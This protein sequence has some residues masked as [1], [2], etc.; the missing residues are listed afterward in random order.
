[1]QEN[2]S[3]Y[4]SFSCERRLPCTNQMTEEAKRRRFT[5]LNISAAVLGRPRT[6]NSSR[7]ETDLKTTDDRISLRS[8]V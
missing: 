4:A 5:M 1:M 3:S 8:L 2:P 7:P 6:P